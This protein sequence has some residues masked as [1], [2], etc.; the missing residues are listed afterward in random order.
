MSLLNLAYVLVVVYLLAGVGANAFRVNPRKEG[1]P[2]FRAFAMGVYSCKRSDYAGLGWALI[3]L[4]RILLV[5]VP[6]LLLYWFLRG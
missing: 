6:L 5:A 3:I 1:F 2:A 4:Q